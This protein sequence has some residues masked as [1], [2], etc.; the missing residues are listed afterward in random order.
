MVTFHSTTKGIVAF[1]VGVLGTLILYHT[2]PTII[3]I[4][5]AMH[6]FDD[7]NIRLISYGGYLITIILM[8]IIVPLWLVF[9]EDA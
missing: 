8:V 3:K 4:F 9:K 7:A 2:V 5:T 6:L 1:C